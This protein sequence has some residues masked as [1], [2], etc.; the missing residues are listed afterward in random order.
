MA[1]VMAA[2]PAVQNIQVRI[3]LDR[4]GH[5]SDG[6]KEARAQDAV[7]GDAG[8]DGAGAGV[9]EEAGEDDAAEDGPPRDEDEEARAVA[10]GRVEVRVR[11][12]VVLDRQP[13]RQRALHATVSLGARGPS[14]SA[15]L[16]DGE[17][18]D[19][20]EEHCSPVREPPVIPQ[21]FSR[22]APG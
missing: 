9:E 6:C 15:Y 21:H 3:K 14:I 4:L 22:D 18:G 8:E 13:R 7:G 11:V 20:A 10:R 12:R 16:D 19:K 5:V 2:A 17:E 1:W